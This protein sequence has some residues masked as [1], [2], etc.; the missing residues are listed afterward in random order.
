[1]LEVAASARR[2]LHISKK[3]GLCAVSERVLQGFL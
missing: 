1:M 3:Q 2:A